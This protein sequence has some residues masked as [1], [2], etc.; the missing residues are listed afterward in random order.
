MNYEFFIARHIAG[1]YS[2]NLTGPI[3]KIAVTS[4]AIGIAV[5]IISVAVVTGYQFQIRDKVISF[6]SHI[7]ITQYNSNNSFESVPINNNPIFLQELCNVQGIRHIQSFAVKAGIIKTD[8]QI[9]GIVLKGIDKDYDWDFLNKKIIEGNAIKTNDTTASNDIIISKKVANSLNLKISDPLRIYFISEG[10]TAPR[11]RKF[12]IS[13]IY[14]TGMEELD[15]LYA[16][17]DIKHIRKLNDWDDTQISGFELLIDDFDKLENIAAQINDIISYD[18]DAVTIKESFPE[19]FDWIQLFDINVIIILT[20]MVLVASI[21]MISALLILILEKTNMIGILKTI[22]AKNVSIIKIFLYNGLYIIVRGLI[23]G[24]I[25]AL[26]LCLIQIHTGIITLNQETYYVSVVPIN[27]NVVH[28][29][30]INAGTVLISL[31]ML[32]LPSYIITRISPLKA[33]RFD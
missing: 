4:I 11:G 28:I 29:V 15:K 5:M 7:Q 9:Q 8:E 10:R 12:T 32:L 20:L 13:G 30:A 25:L 6:G 21:N 31:L 16:I 18:L 26:V 3:V 33:I 23:F 17:C 27:L 14:E 2:G 19:I 24:N 22:G 1:K